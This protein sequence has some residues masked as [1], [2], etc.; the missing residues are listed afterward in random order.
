M[1]IL[2]V[3]IAVLFTFTLGGCVCAG[4]DN[5]NKA[6]TPIRL[7]I[8]LI[9][10]SRIIGVPIIESASIQTPYAKINLPLDQVLTIKIEADHET[11]SIDLRN[12]DKLKGA[13]QLEPVKL[14]TLFGNVSIRVEQIKKVDVVVSGA[15]IS[16]TLSHGLVLY[17]S[18]DKD[19]GDRVADASGNGHDGIVKGAKWTPTGIA[20]GAYSF[21]GSDY[22][23]IGYQPAGTQLTLSA[24]IKTS[25]PEGS[26]FF[27]THYTE[28]SLWLL[29]VEGSG[30][31]PKQCARIA[32]NTG[33]GG[34]SLFGTSN[35]QDGQWHHVAATIDSSGA[36]LYVDGVLENQN[37]VPGRWTGG[38]AAIGRSLT[39]YPGY[40]SGLA[41]EVMIFNRPLSASEIK[42]IYDTQ[43]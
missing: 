18:F 11:A 23:S 15:G 37:S 13:I 26:Y 39:G 19:D 42:Q 24:W 28:T 40:Y 8:A 5:T 41:D 25:S 34:E 35:V 43:K 1:K 10:G 33:S 16:D 27:G 32:Y 36:K 21:G 30:G 31:F 12:G 17:Y 14:E 2:S 7:E 29:T 38:N 20:G 22:I 9:D 6:P 3:G 4:L